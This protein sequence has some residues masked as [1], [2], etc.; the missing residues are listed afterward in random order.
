ME[1]DN[2]DI[3]NECNLISLQ[4]FSDTSIEYLNAPNLQKLCIKQGQYDELNIN[5]IKFSKLTYLELDVNSIGNLPLSLKTMKCL[6]RVQI[7]NIHNLT[8]LKH[9]ILD[10][11]YN[12]SDIP[13]CVTILEVNK[14][15]EDLILPSHIL[16]FIGGNG[17]NGNITLNEN[18]IEANFGDRFNKNLILPKTLKKLTLGDKFSSWITFNDDLEYLNLEQVNNIGSINLSGIPKKTKIILEDFISFLK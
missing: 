7:K 16:L 10:K 17:F 8:N 5:L 18:L 2:S 13:T 14:H 12:I 1:I 11:I 15:Q 3:N 4:I 9:L 6:K